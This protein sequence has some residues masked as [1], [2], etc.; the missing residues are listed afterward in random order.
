LVSLLKEADL[1]QFIACEPSRKW[2]GQRKSKPSRKIQMT[3]KT[4][5]R[6]FVYYSPPVRWRQRLKQ[7]FSGANSRT[8]AAVEQSEWSAR[9]T[10][11]LEVTVE[12]VESILIRP[13]GSGS[14]E[15]LLA[16]LEA[17]THTDESPRKTDAQ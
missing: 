1:N 11:T 8:E 6:G 16:N 5:M 2:L 15:Q 9:S 12:K 10:R 4:K 14:S 3:F 7:L 13:R 17:E